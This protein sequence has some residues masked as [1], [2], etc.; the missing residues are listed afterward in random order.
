MARIHDTTAPT[1]DFNRRRIEAFA[2]L[3]ML[4]ASKRL[5][6]P[7][8]VIPPSDFTEERDAVKA[9]R[10]AFGTAPGTEP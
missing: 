7:T 10:Y 2:R 3:S 6:F 5:Y 9:L 4:M 1:T 8:P